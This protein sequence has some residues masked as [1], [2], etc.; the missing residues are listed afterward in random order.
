MKQADNQCVLSL[1]ANGEL[2]LNVIIEIEKELKIFLVKLDLKL[3][4]EID[5]KKFDFSTIDYFN[6]TGSLKNHFKKDSMNFE[7]LYL[8]PYGPSSLSNEVFGLMNLKREL[9]EN[10]LN[11]VVNAFK[12]F[13][14]EKN[15]IK[16]IKFKAEIININQDSAKFKTLG[17]IV[18]RLVLRESNSDKDMEAFKYKRYRHLDISNL[19]EIQV[20][21]I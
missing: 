14:E 3:L 12:G 1:S 7:L 10:K 21:G 11:I 8:V 17:K 4:N 6:I 9:V 13:R 2:N 15:I 20:Q 5:S 18:E 16:T 19:K